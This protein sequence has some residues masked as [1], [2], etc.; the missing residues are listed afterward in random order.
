MKKSFILQV[1]FKSYS[2]EDCKSRVFCI[3]K[4]QRQHR[5]TSEIFKDVEHEV[6]TKQE[7]LTLLEQITRVVPEN[8][9]L[10]FAKRMKVINWEEVSY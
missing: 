6:W 8:D 10:P 4:H 5:V 1:K 2:E 3:G 7:D 9:S